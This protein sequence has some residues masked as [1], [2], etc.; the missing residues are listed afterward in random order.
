MNTNTF[1]GP[2]STAMDHGGHLTT[3]WKRRLT[4]LHSLNACRSSIG[5]R[6]VGLLIVLGGLLCALPTLLHVS[7]Q[8]TGFRKVF[9][10]SLSH[11][12]LDVADEKDRLLGILAAG[13]GD[14]G[15]GQCRIG[16]A[17]RHVGCAAFEKSRS[18]ASRF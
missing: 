1:H 10:G 18:Q 15:R 3:F 4:M 12:F 6:T 8:A 5:L 13:F 17:G 11:Y 14:Q 16:Q 7:A 2:W 9:T